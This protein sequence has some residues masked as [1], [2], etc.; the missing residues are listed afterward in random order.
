MDPRDVI[1]AHGP[2]I[3]R[4]AAAYERNPAIREDLVQDIL[5]AVVSVLPRLR[6]PLRLKAFVLRVAHNR[7]VSHV[8]RRMRE[9]AAAPPSEDIAADAPTQEQALIAGQRSARL[10]EAIRHLSL[11]YRQVVMLVLEDLS[12]AEIADILG[13]TAINVGVRVNR[14]KQQLKE[15]LGHDG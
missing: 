15:L 11:P 5:L 8:V 2:A 9:P 12:H 13:I 10:M 1:A 6:D 14:A 4:I 7:A 3:A